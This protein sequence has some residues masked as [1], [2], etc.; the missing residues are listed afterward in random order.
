MTRDR[1]QKAVQEDLK[2]C[3]DYLRLLEAVRLM[4]LTAAYYQWRLSNKAKGK[5]AR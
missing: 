2:K 4:V 5:K 3:H 1:C